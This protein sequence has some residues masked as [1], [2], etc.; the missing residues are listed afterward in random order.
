MWTGLLEARTQQGKNEVED[1]SPSVDTSFEYDH[2]QGIGRLA[3]EAV[4]RSFAGGSDS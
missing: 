2:G 4:V 1:R 3:L